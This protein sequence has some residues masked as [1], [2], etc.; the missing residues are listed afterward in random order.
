MSAKLDN[1]PQ[2]VVN[3]PPAEVTVN[4]PP[5]QVTVNV[6]PAQVEVKNTVNVPEPKAKPK[7]KAKI[8]T[9]SYGTVT[10]IEES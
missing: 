1:P 5:A 9:D 4:V 2:V 8:T 10:G 7:R 3:V 6:P